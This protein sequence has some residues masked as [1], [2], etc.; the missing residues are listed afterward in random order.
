M[1][2]GM[3]TLPSRNGLMDL[4]WE[5]VYHAAKTS[6]TMK[7]LRLLQD[8]SSQH[9]A[10]ALVNA[11]LVPVEGA[12]IDIDP[13]VWV[14]HVSNAVAMKEAEDKHCRS[15]TWQF[16]SEL[17][18]LSL[19][20]YASLP[21]QGAVLGMSPAERKLSFSR[22]LALFRSLLAI[23]GFRVMAGEA[24][25]QDTWDT[26]AR[27]VT[28][29]DTRFLCWLLVCAG[30]NT[31]PDDMSAAPDVVRTAQRVIES[32]QK[33]WA[34]TLCGPRG[35]AV[36]LPRRIASLVIGFLGAPCLMQSREPAIRRQPCTLL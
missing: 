21:F 20:R 12:F 2:A 31:E 22:R 10:G 18:H 32:Q 36:R 19:R 34:H 5:N 13:Q 28:R 3:T 6:S 4:N 25:L 33:M 29:D 23:S 16:I 7:L 15:D 27:S 30:A 17:L 11:G 24:R 9:T 26:C 35:G 1:G 8:L 14:Q